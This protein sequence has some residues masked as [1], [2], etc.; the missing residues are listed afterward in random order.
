M[1]K[2]PISLVTCFKTNS[3][4]M[5]G[6]WSGQLYCFKK[7]LLSARHPMAGPLTKVD[8]CK[9]PAFLVDIWQM[10]SDLNWWL[11]ISCTLDSIS[12]ILHDLFMTVDQNCC[13]L[14]DFQHLEMACDLQLP[15]WLKWHSSGT[16]FIYWHCCTK[17]LAGQQGVLGIIIIIK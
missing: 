17:E 3:L 1:A 14:H 8:T 6:N 10:T 15:T 11:Q 4:V 13:D 2:G 16:Y 7:G 9:M 5:V 12:F